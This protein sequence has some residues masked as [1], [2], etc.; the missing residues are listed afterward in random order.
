MTATDA[1]VG[2]TATLTLD[3][4]WREMVTVALL[5]TDRRDPPPP[6]SVAWPTSRPTTRGHTVATAAAAGGRVHGRPTRRCAAGRSRDLVAPPDDDPRPVTPPAATATWRR[7][8][9]DWPVLEDEWVL[10]VVHSGRRLAPE[11]VVPLLAR[12]R[13]DATRHARVLVAAG[14]LGQWMIDWSPRLACTATNSGGDGSDRRAARAGHRARAAAGAWATPQQAAH[15]LAGGLSSGV[16][17]S[18]TA[19]CW[20]T[21]SPASTRPRCPRWARRSTASTRRRRPS[22]SR[23]RSPTSPTSATT[24]SP[25]WSPM[26]TSEPQFQPGRCPASARRA[27]VRPRA[28]RARR[29]STIASGRPAGGCRRGR[30]SP[31]SLGGTLADGTVITPKYVGQRRLVEIAVATLATDRALLLLGVPGTAKTWVSEHL[32]AAISGDSTCWQARAGHR[33]HRRGELRYGWNYARLLAEGSQ[34]G[35]AGAQPGVPG[36]ARGSIVAW[37]S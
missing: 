21:W 35:G 15:T 6:P 37:R 22:A 33:R 28:G 29:A 11:L 12:H 4:Y 13:T 27:R 1:G 30:W 17:G 19:P 32:A 7:I 34:R 3:E 10:A 25:N 14:P 20:S 26:T 23:S 18:A 9:G 2:T 5:G 36:D 31:T 16:F 24:C 8:V